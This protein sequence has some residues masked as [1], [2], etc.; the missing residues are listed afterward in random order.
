MKR[1]IAI[2]QGVSKGWKD[3]YFEIGHDVC[4]YVQCW[5][6]VDVLP[7]KLINIVNQRSLFFSRVDL[8][9][10]CWIKETWLKNH[11]KDYD[12]TLMQC[13]HLV[14]ARTLKPA[15]NVK[16]EYLLWKEVTSICLFLLLFPIFWEVGHRGSCCD[17]CQR[18]F[19][20][21]SPLG[22]L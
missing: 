20:L 12:I 19:C 21:C 5:R 4:V 14:F 11:C 10:H 6:G 17:L 15:R 18:V 3:W 8:Q 2:Y 16:E 22:V 7:W 1:T 13:F 9:A